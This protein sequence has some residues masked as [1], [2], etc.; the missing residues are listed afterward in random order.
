MSFTWW[1][2]VK[3]VSL[4]TLH[5]VLGQVLGVGLFSIG[6]LPYEDL[7]NTCCTIIVLK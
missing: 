4:V 7:I 2:H 3:L 1:S 6:F 5:V